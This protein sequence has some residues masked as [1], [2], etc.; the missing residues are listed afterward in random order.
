MKLEK[1]T[2]KQIEFMDNAKEGDMLFIRKNG[3]QFK[4]VEPIIKHCYNCADSYIPSE[5]PKD[6]K[7]GFCCNRCE[8]EH[9]E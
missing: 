5:R 8:M 3:K 2:K 7:D 1:P 6:T 4:Q 9:Y